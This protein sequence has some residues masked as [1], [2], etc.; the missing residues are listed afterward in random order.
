VVTTAKAKFIRKKLR[1]PIKSLL[2][3]SVRVCSGPGPGAY[4][5]Y[6]ELQNA[7]LEAIDSVSED[8]QLACFPCVL[9]WPLTLITQ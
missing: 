2:P 5:P 3:G 1:G 7:L 9:L 4:D 6:T 8:H